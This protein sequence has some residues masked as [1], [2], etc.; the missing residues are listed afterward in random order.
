VGGDWYDAFPVGEGRLGLV[1]GD[2]VGHNLGS[3]SAMNQVRNAIRAFA[4][5]D[6]APGRVLRRSNSALSRLLPGALATVCC[7]VLE[8]GSGR[9]VYANA[10][11]PPPLLVAGDR[12]RYLEAAGG[13]M[14]GVAG[15]ATYDE[16]AEQ[17]APGSGLL[18]YSDGL[19]EDR[20]RSIDE[21]L[22]ALADAFRGVRARSAGEI[23]ERSERLLP[24]GARADDV[25]LLAM[26]LAD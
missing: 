23:C 24:A 21:G 12:A 7:A 9:L 14:L 20:Q 15:D 19:V 1:I 2:V 4:V 25:C 18:L 6:P 26:R 8:V 13:L 11:H 16:A 22:T 10:G 5:E 17:L 3:A